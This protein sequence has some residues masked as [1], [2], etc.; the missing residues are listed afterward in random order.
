VISNAG[1][2]EAFPAAPRERFLGSGPWRLIAPGRPD[3]PFSTPD[4]DPRWLYH[5]VV[6]TIDCLT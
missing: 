3:Q 5:D 2:V 6:V 1:I 4:A